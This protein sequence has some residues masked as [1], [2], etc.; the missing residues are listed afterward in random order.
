MNTTLY[1]S[2][3][4]FVVCVGVAVACICRFN[5]QETKDSIALWTKYTCLLVF[6]VLMGA[7]PIFFRTYPSLG[8]LVISCT[9]LGVMILTFL[10]QKGGLDGSYDC[11]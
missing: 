7:Q 10:N 2:I 5:S 4:N 6:A 8:E 11:N 3:A 9:V 1:L